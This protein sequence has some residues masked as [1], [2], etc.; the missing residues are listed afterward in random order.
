MYK[1]SVQDKS[2]DIEHKESALW[3]NGE[4]IELDQRML[5]D[6]S[7]HIIKDHRSHKIHLVDYDSEEK[8]VSLLINNK[9]ITV[10]IKDKMDLLLEKMGI[11]ITASTKGGK[12][13]SPMP[14]LVI[15]IK[16]EK[17]QAVQKGDTLLILEAMKMENVIKAPAD[18][19]ISAIH[20]TQGQAVEKNEVL[21]DL[22]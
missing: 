11:D 17:D 4:R 20:I 13:K 16:V 22:G 7:I 5:A 18:G 14:G 19:T 15:E 21:I 10:H 1:V 2:Y 6:R 9:A 3:I 12:V 8:T